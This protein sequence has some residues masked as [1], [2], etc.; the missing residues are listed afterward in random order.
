MSLLSPST[1]TILLLCGYRRNGKDTFAGQLKGSIPA[2]KYQW[3]TI[4]PPKSKFTI[5]ANSDYQRISFAEQ[6]KLDVLAQLGVDKIFDLDSLEQYKDVPLQD[7][8]LDIPKALQNNKTLRDYLISIGEE[9]RAADPF[10]WCKA[11]FRNYDPHRDYVITDWRFP[12]EYKYITNFIV[13]GKL[14][15]VRVFRGEIA[16]PTYDGE[17]YLDNVAT[18]V[19]VV[20]E[21]NFKFQYDSL[22]KQF[23]QYAD[24]L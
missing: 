7:I 20:P 15:T 8:P 16:I 23:P 17:H 3:K 13:P 4:Q 12:N 2:D 9:K 5:P 10:H 6:L 21:H 18:D 19:V 24:Y 22:I 14:I 1:G 11:A